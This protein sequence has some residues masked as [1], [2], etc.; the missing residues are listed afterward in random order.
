MHALAG[1]LTDSA[2]A[3]VRVHAFFSQ[4]VTSASVHLPTAP[5]FFLKLKAASGLLAVR[6]PLP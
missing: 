5:Q 1:G 3:D 6:W 2:T 4:A